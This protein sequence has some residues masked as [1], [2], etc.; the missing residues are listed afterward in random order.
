MIP[1]FLKF[2]FGS[3][4]QFLFDQWRLTYDYTFLESSNIYNSCFLLLLILIA[5]S[6]L[7]QFPGLWPHFPASLLNSK[8][9][10]LLSRTRQY[11]YYTIVTVFWYLLQRLSSYIFSL[12]ERQLISCRK[13]PSAASLPLLL[14]I[15][16][17][18][19]CNGQLTTSLKKSDC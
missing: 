4:L 18:T 10:K 11:E 2:S 16:F 14:T 19:S 12:P 13:I 15:C 8:Y 17:S 7:G 3:S 9:F 6:S 1:L 5:G